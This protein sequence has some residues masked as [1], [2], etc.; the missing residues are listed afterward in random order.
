MSSESSAVYPDLP[1]RGITGELRFNEPMARHTSWKV[2]G[3]ADTER[4]YQVCLLCLI[5]FPKVISSY[6]PAHHLRLM[7]GIIVQVQVYTG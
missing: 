3:V 2:G 6:V 5:F 7:P 4:I 1:M